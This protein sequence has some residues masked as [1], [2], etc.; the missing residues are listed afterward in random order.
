MINI[1]DDDV[2]AAA[3]QLIVRRGQAARQE[4][5][6]RVAELERL[7]RWPEQAIAVRVLTAVEKLLDEN[8]A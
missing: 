2:A 4:A 3:R 7:A 6:E 8:R 1:H 5:A